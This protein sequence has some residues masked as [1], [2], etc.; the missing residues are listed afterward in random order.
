MTLGEINNSMDLVLLRF[1]SYVLK[2]F[3]R[4]IFILVTLNVSRISL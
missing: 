1:L 4:R 2:L 3:E